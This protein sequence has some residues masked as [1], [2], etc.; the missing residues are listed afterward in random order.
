MDKI[1]GTR[2]DELTNWVDLQS[3][4]YNDYLNT[5]TNSDIEMN[6][7]RTFVYLSYNNKTESK[8]LYKATG[9]KRDYLK[10]MLDNLP[11][12]Y[13][14]SKDIEKIREMAL[15]N[16]VE[17]D[18]LIQKL[19]SSIS[20]VFATTSTIDVLEREY[21]IKADKTKPFS[22]RYN[23]LQAYHFAVYNDCTLPNLKRVLEL[24]ECNDIYISTENGTNIGISVSVNKDYMNDIKI[25]LSRYLPAQLELVLTNAKPWDEL[26]QGNWQGVLDLGNW[27]VLLS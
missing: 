5:E 16:L 23:L 4:W 1:I 3:T 22:F 9:T 27:G 10:R 24:L 25:F 2:W 6:V 14:L 18:N 19:D 20:V 11:D 15:I 8:S 26:S 7:N 17:S 13:K 12:Y 21:G